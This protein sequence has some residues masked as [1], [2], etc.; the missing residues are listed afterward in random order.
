MNTLP[1]CSFNLSQLRD[2]LDVTLCQL[3]VR[4]FCSSLCDGDDTDD[5]D[6]DGRD[7]NDIHDDMQ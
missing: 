4:F 2:T 6:N 7:D 5:A 1:A 3:A